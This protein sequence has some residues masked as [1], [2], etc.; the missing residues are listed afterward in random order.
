MPTIALS[1]LGGAVQVA[2]GGGR[3]ALLLGLRP[4][5]LPLFPCPL[6]P[7]GQFGGHNGAL[8]QQVHFD[9]DLF[10]IGSLSTRACLRLD[11][12][13]QNV[14]YADTIRSVGA[15]PAENILGCLAQEGLRLSI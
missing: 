4:A 7:C 5:L 11:P 14:G 9:K 1:T 6:A 8:L 13:R 10:V 3:G 15:L 2:A 12:F